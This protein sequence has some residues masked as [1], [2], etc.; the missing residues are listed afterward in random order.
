MVSRAAAWEKVWVSAP[1]SVVTVTSQSAPPEWCATPTV[2]WSWPRS[3]SKSVLSAMLAGVPTT[4]LILAK[5][6]SQVVLTAS[7]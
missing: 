6:P 2:T 4:G 1:T 7:Q 5:C 3:Q